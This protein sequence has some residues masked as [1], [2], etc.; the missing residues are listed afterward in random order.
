M[1]AALGRDRNVLC[2]PQA[3]DCRLQETGDVGM[4]D[5]EKRVFSLTIRLDGAAREARFAG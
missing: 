1:T 2:K 3:P 4:T 5:L